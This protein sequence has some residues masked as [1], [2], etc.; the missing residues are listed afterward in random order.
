M[1]YKCNI[2]LKFLQDIDLFSRKLELYYN[3][4]PEK[5]SR[6]GTF[7]TVIYISIFL[8]IFLYKFIR[9]FEKHNGTFYVTY[10]FEKEP[11]SIK[12]SNE[13]FYGGFVLE[14]PETY[15]EFIDETIYYYSLF[16][17]ILKIN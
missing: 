15:D 11:P 6:I 12:L 1:K 5:T 3:G 2:K 4:K 17:Y 13:N 10:T 9:V 8:T 16:F 7:F 14:N